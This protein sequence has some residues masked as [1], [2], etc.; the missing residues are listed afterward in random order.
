MQLRDAVD[1]VAADDGQVRHAYAPI[2][3][4]I[5]DGHRAQTLRLAGI[6][7]LHDAQKISIYK[8]DD[9]QMPRQQAL[10]HRHRPGFERLR[11]QRMIGVREHAFG[12][13]PAFLPGQCVLIDEQPHQ[14]RNRHSRVGIVELNGDR[15]GQGSERSALAQ[16]S[17][18]NILQAGADEKILLL[19]PKLLALRRRI[20]RIQDPRQIFRLQLFLHGGGIVAGVEGVDLER[21]DRAPRPKPQMIDGRAAIAGNQLIEPDGVDVIRAHPTQRCAA[22]TGV[23]AGASLRPPNRTV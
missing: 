19:E 20:V 17:A 8:I 14:F 10:E 6:G 1:F 23:P 7:R 11:Q 13:L 21:C 2:A 5:D 15:V 12:Y 9:F 3:A 16:V 18:Q 4:V 22:L